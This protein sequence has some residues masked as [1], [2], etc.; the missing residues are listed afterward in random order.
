MFEYKGGERFDFS[1]DDDTWVFV[2]R[3]LTVDL[4]G[5]HGKQTGYF[6]LD[7]DTDGAGSGHCRRQRDGQRQWLV[8]RRHELHRHARAPSCSSA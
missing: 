3:K 6:I 7:A 4:G 2:N 5:L 8:L 1:G